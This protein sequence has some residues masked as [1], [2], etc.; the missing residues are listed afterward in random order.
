MKGAKEYVPM[1]VCLSCWDWVVVAAAQNQNGN[2][3]NTNGH[4]NH[5]KQWWLENELALSV[6]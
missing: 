4:G 1:N 5:D 6:S 3:I 2:K